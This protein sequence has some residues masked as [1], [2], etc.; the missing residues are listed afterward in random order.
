MGPEIPIVAS[1]TPELNGRFLETRFF[2]RLGLVDETQ[3]HK[4]IVIG[5]EAVLKPILGLWNY[6]NVGRTLTNP[7]VDDQS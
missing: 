7:S 2:Q 1:F 4:Y 6:T 5:A 3:E